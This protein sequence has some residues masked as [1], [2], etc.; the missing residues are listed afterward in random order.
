ML[1]RT[2]I[3]RKVTRETKEARGA[4]KVREGR[5]RRDITFVLRYIPT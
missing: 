4:G 3:S 1:N 2:S 5:S